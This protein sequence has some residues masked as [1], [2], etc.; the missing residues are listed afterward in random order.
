MKRWGLLFCCLLYGSQIIAYP[1]IDWNAD[2][3]PLVIIKH[4]DNSDFYYESKGEKLFLY[5]SINNEIEDVNFASGSQLGLGS[6]NVFYKGKQSDNGVTVYFNV[7]QKLVSRAYPDNQD[8]Y[9]AVSNDIIDFKNFLI[10]RYNIENKYLYLQTIFDDQNHPVIIIK[11]NF[12]WGANYQYSKFLTDGDLKIGYSLV[13][14]KPN[15]GA[16]FHF[17]TIKINND[18]FDKK[19][20][21]QDRCYDL[22][23]KHTL[24]P[25]TCPSGV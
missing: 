8:A 21:P 3:T 1:L 24:I 20:T 17:E 5:Q 11:R 7:I 12:I 10:L 14:D 25:T 16:P 19:V 6:I 23:I 22:D 15:L 4:K 9:G 2:R 13:G 18:F